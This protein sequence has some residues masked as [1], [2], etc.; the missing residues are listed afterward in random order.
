MIHREIIG[1]RYYLRGQF[2]LP[3]EGM[4]LNLII[5]IKLSELYF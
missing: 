4:D 5:M 1:P 2:D 3:Y